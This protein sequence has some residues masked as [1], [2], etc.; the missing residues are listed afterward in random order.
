MWYMLMPRRRLVSGLDWILTSCLSLYSIGYECYGIVIDY[1]FCWFAP[2]IV[3]VNCIAF[4]CSATSALLHA[5]RLFIWL[6]T[7]EI[8]VGVARPRYVYP[9]SYHGR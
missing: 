4:S 1:Y 2:I 8:L 6:R 3:I 5:N 7:F 9:T